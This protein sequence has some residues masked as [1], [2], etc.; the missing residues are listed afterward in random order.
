MLHFRRM[1]AKPIVIALVVGGV[2][3]YLLTQTKRVDIGTA[4]I[5]RLKLEGGGLRLNVRLPIINRS[6]FPV[7]VSGFL[8]RLLYNGL[9]IGSLQQVAPVTLAPRAVSTPEFT[10]VISYAGLLTSTPLLGIL[11]SL[12]KKYIGVSLPGIPSD[13]VLTA[14]ELT[15]ALSALRIQGTLYVGSLGID[16]NESLT[17]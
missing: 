15:N 5:S 11:N 14:G 1:K 12:A 6:D 7:P 9:E 13:Q 4:S 8:G 16:I 2:L 17:A 3:W 10:T